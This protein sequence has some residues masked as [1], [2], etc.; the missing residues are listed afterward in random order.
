M[1]SCSVCHPQT[2]G[3]V[4]SSNKHILESLKKRLYDA[5]GLWV[6]ELPST[7][8]AIRTTVHSRTRDT[9]FNLAFGSDAVIHVEIGIN[10]LQV[11]HY[12]SE[13]NEANL[14]A[15]LDL[16]NEIREEASVKAAAR[17]MRVAQYYNKQV[18][19][20]VFEEGDLVLRN[21]QA[22]RP[23]GEQRKLSPTW[24]GPYLVSFMIGNEVYRL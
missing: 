7:L 14:R 6:E 3:Q 18:K 2:N 15:N 11:A 9:P 13:Q 22:S 20:K 21:C 19:A 16:L 4:E 17:Q 1:S 8:W 10:S 23:A 12:D 5:K 24:D